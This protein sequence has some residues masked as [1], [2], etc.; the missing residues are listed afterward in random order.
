L[1]PESAKLVGDGIGGLTLDTGASSTVVEVPASEIRLVAIAPE[2]DPISGTVDALIEVARS[3][4]ELKPGLRATAQILLPGEIEGVVLAD[5]SVVDD[6]GVPVVYVQVEGESFSRRA[7]S[8]R[9]RQGNKVLIDGLE[10][11]ERVVVVGGAAI[12]RASLLA[13][14]SVEGHVH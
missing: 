6:A 2:V 3:V 11:G 1:T 14:G 13:S 9:H 7:V 10:L 12:R 8:V 4:D 5:S